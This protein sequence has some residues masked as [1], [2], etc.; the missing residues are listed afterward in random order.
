MIEIIGYHGTNYKNG[1]IILKDKA[2]IVSGTVRDWLGAGVYFFEDD[3]HQ[4]Y[5][6]AKFKKG[7][8]EHDKIMV[9]KTK[10][11]VNEDKYLNLLIDDD[12][13]FLKIFAKRIKEKIETMEKDVGKW[14]HKEG[15]IIDFFNKLNEIEKIDVVK[16][17]Y[18]VPKS[19][20]LY[21]CLPIQLQVCVKNINCIE[22]N[23]IERVDCDAYRNARK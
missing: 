19:E 14:E 23:S 5:M 8:L 1:T 7:V 2:Y 20:P 16:A 11:H 22:N 17:A 4:A 13:R 3:M 18:M 10:I 15:L 21:G 6:F 12:R 9:L